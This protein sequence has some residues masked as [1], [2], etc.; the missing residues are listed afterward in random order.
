LEVRNEVNPSVEIIV[1]N[2][3]SALVW[4]LVAW[5]YNSRV[6]HWTFGVGLILVSESNSKSFNV[7][8][9][10]SF[11]EED[12]SEE[13]LDSWYNLNEVVASCKE[14]VD[15]LAKVCANRGNEVLGAILSVD[16][17][18]DEVINVSRKGVNEIGAGSWSFREL[19]AEV[20]GWDIT[21][22]LGC[23]VKFIEICAVG[24]KSLIFSSEGGEEFLEAFKLCLGSNC[25][26]SF[27]SVSNVSNFICSGSAGIFQSFSEECFEGKS[28]LNET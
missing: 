23:F 4:N 24:C 10:L 21:C 15:L 26:L 27:D 5:A 16:E 11:N 7:F 19:N 17:I 22:E 9:V 18:S 25:S 8:A 14:L 13:S 12:I 1:R 28:V 3:I 2:D 20:V 6:N